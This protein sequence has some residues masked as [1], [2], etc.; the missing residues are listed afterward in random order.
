MGAS[1]DIE[2]VQSLAEWHSRYRSSVWAEYA[3]G[4]SKVLSAHH[5]I[6]AW[7]AIS[8]HFEQAIQIDSLIE[9]EHQYYV[10]R[11]KD[12]ENYCEYEFSAEKDS[13]YGLLFEESQFYCN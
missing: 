13:T 3:L 10:I 11:R 12:P 6:T 9:D 7:S 4:L 2:Q 1:F 8:K 5:E